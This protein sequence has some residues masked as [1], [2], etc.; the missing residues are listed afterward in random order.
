MD[1]KTAVVH[2][3]R[4]AMCSVNA[5]GKIYSQRIIIRNF[6]YFSVSRSLYY[7]PRLDYKLPSIKTLS[8]ITSVVSKLDEEA[9][10]RGIFGSLPDSQKL[11]VLMHDEIYVKQSLLYHGGALFRKAVDNPKMLAKTVLAIMIRCHFGGPKFISKMLPVSNLKS[12]FIRQQADATVNAI[13]ESG[14]Q[15]TAIVCDGH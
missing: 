6:Q 14:G 13:F 12:S 10:L 11:C 1:N 4:A 5:G 8:R 2:E 9:F 15:V 3:H 7:R